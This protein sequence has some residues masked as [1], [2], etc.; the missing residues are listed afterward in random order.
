[1][2]LWVTLFY[3]R[4]QLCW[5]PKGINAQVCTAP[6]AAVS[7]PTCLCTKL[8]AVTQQSQELTALSVY[9]E[10][11]HSSLSLSPSCLCSTTEVTLVLSFA[12]SHYFVSVEKGPIE[13]LWFGPSKPLWVAMSDCSGAASQEQLLQLPQQ[14][15]EKFAVTAMLLGPTKLC[16]RQHYDYL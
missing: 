11:A 14:S 7:W 10:N 13:M 2:Q 4:S 12:S 3:C 9:T 8:P 15:W 5:L 1:M 16:A 6:G